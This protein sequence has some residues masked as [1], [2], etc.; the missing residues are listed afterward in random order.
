MYIGIGGLT[1]GTM[2]AY[3]RSNRRVTRIV[4]GI[5]W[6]VATLGLMGVIPP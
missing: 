6:A 4:V 3:L 5:M 1:L 2:I